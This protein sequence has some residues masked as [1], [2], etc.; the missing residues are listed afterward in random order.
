MWLHF[1]PFSG[2][3]TNAHPVVEIT[4][5]TQTMSRANEIILSPSVV[6]TDCTLPIFDVETLTP[7]VTV[8][9]NGAF[10]AKEVHHQKT[11]TTRNVEGT[12][13]K[14][15]ETK[16]KI[17]VIKISITACLSIITLNVNG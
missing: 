15:R 11:T 12:S 6:W 10:K 1:C 3:I 7:K 5:V 8:F 2:Y 16:I 9:G 17:Q 14:R 13:L 4:S